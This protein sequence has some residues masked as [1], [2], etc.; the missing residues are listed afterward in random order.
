MLGLELA[1]KGAI[2]AF[3][4]SEKPAAAQF[5]NRLHEAGLLTIPSGNQV[6]RLLPPLNLTRAQAEEGITILERV[7]RGLE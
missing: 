7:V 1:E 4:A 6:L 5:V 3:A 2:P